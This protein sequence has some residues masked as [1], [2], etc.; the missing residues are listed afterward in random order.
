MF[1]QKSHIYIISALDKEVG[2]RSTN[3]NRKIWKRKRDKKM[4]EK[5]K[6]T[7]KDGFGF[8]Y[9][10]KQLNVETLETFAGTKLLEMKWLGSFSEIRKKSVRASLLKFIGNNNQEIFVWPYSTSREVIFTG[11]HFCGFRDFRLNSEI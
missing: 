8:I 1:V 4:T 5:R 7:E 9:E 2:L 10:D 11:T 6:L 3:F